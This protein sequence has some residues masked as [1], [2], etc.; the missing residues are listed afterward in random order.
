MSEENERKRWGGVK[1]FQI[2]HSGMDSHR[3]DDSAVVNKGDFKKTVFCFS[4]F[5]SEYNIL[6]SRTDKMHRDL[7]LPLNLPPPPCI[8]LSLC[9]EG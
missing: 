6:E 7:S 2:G 9:Y 3:R 8:F 4:I 5:L 1:I